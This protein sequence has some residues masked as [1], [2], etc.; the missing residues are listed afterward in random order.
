MTQQPTDVALHPALAAVTEPEPFAVQPQA[1]TRLEQLHA[2]YVDAKAQADE[3]ASRLKSITDALKAELTRAAPEHTRIELASPHGPT[4]RLSY[5]ER[6]TVDS[7]RLKREDPVTYVR[8][9]KK[10]GSWTLRAAGGR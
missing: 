7:G 9:A 6:W 10:G 8:F 1:G 5:V 3:A 2:A 4:L